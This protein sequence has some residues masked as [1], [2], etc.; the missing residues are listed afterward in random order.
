M[1]PWPLFLD[2]TVTLHQRMRGTVSQVADIIHDVHAWARLHP[3]I[4]KVEQDPNNP[5]RYEITDRLPGPLHLWEYENSIHVVYTPKED[6]RGQGVNASVTLPQ[7]T[8]FPKLEHQIR[9]KDTEEPGIVEVSEVVEMKVGYILLYNGGL[10]TKSS[11][12]FVPLNSLHCRRTD[13][14]A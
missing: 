11:L 12:G 13:A 5:Q 3:F 14:F 1:G 10:F 7:S 8:V 4:I 9:V 6:E 2:R